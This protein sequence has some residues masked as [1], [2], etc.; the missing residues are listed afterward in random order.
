MPKHPL[1]LAALLTA[2]SAVPAFA[3]FGDKNPITVTLTGQEVEVPVVADPAA[4]VG[5]TATAP[6]TRSCTEIK[7]GA[8]CSKTVRSWMISS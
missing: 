1:L 3:D 4:D 6:S 8:A 5:P 7:S 2:V